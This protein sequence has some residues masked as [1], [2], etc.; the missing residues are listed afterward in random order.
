M[1]SNTEAALPGFVN[2]DAK[3]IKFPGESKY[4]LRFSGIDSEADAKAAEDLGFILSDNYP[5]CAAVIVAARNAEDLESKAA[6]FSAKLGMS[7]EL[8][9]KVLE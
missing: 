2:K 1:R 6:A 4:Y 9:M 7:P 3:L 8:C 5:E